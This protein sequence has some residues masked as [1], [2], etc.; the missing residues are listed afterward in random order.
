MAPFKS[1][2]EHINAS[3]LKANTIWTGLTLATGVKR[4]D[5]TP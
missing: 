3:R 1:L 5:V 4:V 2:N